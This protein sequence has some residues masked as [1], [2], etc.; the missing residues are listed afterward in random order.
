M[1]ILA[2]TAYA[3]IAGYPLI[4]GSIVCMYFSKLLLSSYSRAAVFMLQSILHIRGDRRM[5]IF[6][7]SR[8]TWGPGE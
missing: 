6:Q 8:I 2:V 4:W 1:C 3:V 7:P 5:Y